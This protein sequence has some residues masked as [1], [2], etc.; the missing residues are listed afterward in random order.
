[1]F[2]LLFWIIVFEFHEYAVLEVLR[3]QIGLPVNRAVEESLEA[4]IPHDVLGILLAKEILIK[5]RGKI[6]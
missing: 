6:C 2:N 1:M 3:L 4:Q 5:L